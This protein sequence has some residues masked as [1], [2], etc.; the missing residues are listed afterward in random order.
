[1]TSP[2]SVEAD[3]MSRATWLVAGAS[4][5]A[6]LIHL[7]VIAE[8]SG[9]QVVVPVGFAITGVA[10]IAVAAAL[11][12]RRVTRAT[13]GLAIAINA[14]ATAAWVWSRTAG[15]PFDPY[16]G[17]PEAA[18]TID[19]TSAGLQAAAITLAVGLL[20]APRVKVP[21][22]FAGAVAAGAVALAAVVVVAPES[23]APDTQAV[24]ATG[25]AAAPAAGGDG[26][27]HSHGGAA[28]ATTASAAP[29]DHA[30]DMLRID[31]ARCDLAFNPQAY[32]DEAYAMNVDT[33]GGGSMTMAAPSTIADVTRPRLLDGKGSEHLDRLIS[34]TSISS[35][36]GAAAALIVALG[37]ATDEEYD[38]WRRWVAANPGSHSAT[39][40]PDGQP[41]P[42]SMGH[43][44]PT[45]WTA[46]VDRSQCERLEAELAEA[47]E[48]TERYPTVADAT[49]AGWFRVTGYVPGIAAHY[50]NFSLVDSTFELDKPEMLLFDGT[51][52]DSRIVGLSYYVRQDGTASPTQ[53]FV[54]ENDSYHRHFGLCIGAGGVI[55]D[56]TT[57]EEECNAR[58]G[59]KSNGTDGWMSH[60][61]VVPG[62]ESPWG[63]FSGENPILDDALGATSGDDGAEGCATSEARDRYDLEPGESDLAVRG[64]TDEASG[65]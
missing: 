64:T 45:P 46:M 31:R 9:G 3:D 59:T 33:Y 56:S 41:A 16:D 10:Q 18:S 5:A 25:G 55:G 20:V 15:L 39:P 6:G 52:P 29:G 23:P 51:D 28:A 54:G 50:M 37:E 4:A 24:A 61:W 19:V 11:L 27:G 49:E 21:A 14:L 53:G 26:H 48:V 63:V 58:G 43:P 2:T 62:C 32:W 34:L 1:M 12:G 7:S 38:A 60:A 36:E 65:R 17:V 8:H 57:T 40:P 13:L 22:P 42:P 35:G 47:R 30:A 44:G